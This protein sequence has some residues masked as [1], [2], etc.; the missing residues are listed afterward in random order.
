MAMPGPLVSSRRDFLAYFSALGLGGTLFPGVLWAHARYSDITAEIIAEAEKVAG[1]ELSVEQR[2]RIARDLTRNTRSYQAIREVGV[3]NSVPP[4]FRFD[5]VVPEAPAPPAPKAVVGA[6]ARPRGEVVRPA[7]L[8]EVAFWSLA[9]LGAL[10]RTRQVSALELTELYLDRLK[11]YGPQLECVVT[12]TEE[13]ALEQARR[14]DAELAEGEYRGP[15]H[16]IPWGVK[17]MLA[18]RG[19]RTTW[20]ARPYEDQVI[21]EDATVVRRLDEAGA[22]L[23]AKLTLGALAMG[24]RWF[25]GMT[26]NPWNLE[27]GSSGSSAG[28]AAAVVAGLVGFTIGSETHG[29]IVSPST[30][31]GSSGLRPTFGRVSRHGSMALSWSMDKL[32]PLCRSAEDCALVFDAIHGADGKD[33]TAVSHP[34]TWDPTVRLEDLKIGYLRSAFELERRGKEYDDAVLEVLRAEGAELIPFELPDR[35]PVNP[36]S[37]ILY[38]E[39]GASFSDLT[40]SGRVDL[41]EDSAWPDIFRAAHFIPAVE[42]IQ[43]NRIRRLITSELNEA[44]EGLDLFVTPSFAPNVLL[45]TNLTGHPA[46]VVPSG[47]TEAGT[48]VSISFIGKLWG[49]AETLAAAHIYQEATGHHKE[50]PPL[51]S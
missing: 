12:L 6:S 43:A 32:G 9:D 41:I 45:M 33:P 31:C 4:A 34:F 8:E 47:F 40:L 27:Q 46:V 7:D 1:I 24:D 36:L 35:H 15:L 11:R 18:V 29:S 17:D 23:V 19:Y 21:D 3:P 26:R 25:G 5:P 10:I 14:A 22:I 44:M 48:P 49:E 37:I 2:S 50:R 38:A 30:R 28:S 20:G 42:Y 13:R 16:G 39:A 51:F